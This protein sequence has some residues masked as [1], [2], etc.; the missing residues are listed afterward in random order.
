MPLLLKQANE[1]FGS[2]I[3]NGSFAFTPSPNHRQGGS[4]H[5]RSVAGG[6]YRGEAKLGRK[7]RGLPY[8]DETRHCR[9][10]NANIILE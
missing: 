7:Q 6:V 5:P 3:P 4:N 9:V 2:Y 1:P 8:G 10:S